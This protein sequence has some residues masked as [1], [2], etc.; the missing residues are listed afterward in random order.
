MNGN[1]ALCIYNK[2]NEP[3]NLKFYLDE[4]VQSREVS[5][6][7][8]DCVTSREVKFENLTVTHYQF[9]FTLMEETQG[10]HELI[11][12]YPDS[13]LH[14]VIRQCCQKNEQIQ[15]RLA[16]QIKGRES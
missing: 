10:A 12:A 7:C 3:W 8:P 14:P 13:Q 15:L 9:N 4:A 5:R 16:I 6:L 2:V 1:T 11:A